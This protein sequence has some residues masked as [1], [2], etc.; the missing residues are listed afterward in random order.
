MP[1]PAVMT[2][3]TDPDSNQPKYDATHC[4]TDPGHALG[5]VTGIAASLQKVNLDIHVLEMKARKA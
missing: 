3:L 2:Y 1:T 4:V 5:K